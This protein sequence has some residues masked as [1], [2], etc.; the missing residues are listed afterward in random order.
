MRTLK[1]ASVIAAFAALTL[2][3]GAALADGLAAKTSQLG[4]EART[5]LAG[6]IA[7]YRKTNPQAFEAV[8]AVGGHRPENYKKFRNPVPTTSRE[9][10]ALGASA[11]LPMLEALAF[12]TP[13]ERAQLTDAEATALTVGMLE[14]VGTLRDP[15]SAPVVH[16]IFASGANNAAVLA[17]AARALGRLGGD[18]EL[19][20]LTAAAVPGNARMLAAIEGLGECRRIEA[21]KHLS[22]L[23]AT[24]SDDRTLETLGLALGSVGSSW[25]WKTRGDA[26]ASEG[27]A[28]R[29]V[30]AKA[31]TAAYPRASGEAQR[32]MQRSLGMVAHPQSLEIIDRARATASP[33]AAASLATLRAR[34]ES[35]I[36][37]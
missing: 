12:E 33:A 14:A 10:R 25:A 15:K 28:V 5:S 29:E 35:K 7:A 36:K 18:A 37:R 27:L 16:A 6:E 19:S 8:R 13:A 23:V 21:A 26:K 34:L 2:G 32:Q 20:A 1:I 9:F 4:A 17:A 3:S 11:L 31:L 24:A 22:S 30:A